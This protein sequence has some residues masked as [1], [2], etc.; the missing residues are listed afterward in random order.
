MAVVRKFYLAAV[1]WDWFVNFIYPFK[2]ASNTRKLSVVINTSSIVKFY[3]KRKVITGWLLPQAIWENLRCPDCLRR[4]CR[5]A[6]HLDRKEGPPRWPF[7][8][9]WIKGTYHVWNL[10]WWVPTHY[11]MET[12]SCFSWT[13]FFM[14]WQGLY[15]KIFC[16]VC[17]ALQMH[18]E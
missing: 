4:V 7:M 1:E 11:G 14:S 17:W 13:M 8:G 6:G 16:A 9:R 18:E 2:C 15:N 12:R 5:D 3:Y 10:S